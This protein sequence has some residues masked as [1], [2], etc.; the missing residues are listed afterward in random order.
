LIVAVVLATRPSTATAWRWFRLGFGAG[1]VYFAGT[2]Y[3]VVTVMTTFGGL[4]DPVAVLVGALLVAY[5]SIYPAFFAVLLGHAV[6]RGGVGMVWLAP[7]FWVAMEW[8]RSWVGG[9]FPWALLGSSLATVLPVVQLASVTGVYGLSLLVVLVSTAAAALTL[10]RRRPDR[11]GAAVV[12]ALTLVIAAAGTM[13]VAGSALTRSGTVI[14]VGLVQGNVA[15]DRKWNPAFRDQILG[16]YL[17]LSQRVIDAG[18]RLVLWP[19]AATPFFFDAESAL[20]APIRQLASLTRTP[21][22]I[23]TD[24]IVRGAGGEPDRYYNAAVL[25]G[26]DGRSHRSYRKMQLVP[27]GEY[28]PLKQLLFFVGPLVEAVSDFSAGTDPIV[29]EAGDS[30]VS[31]AICYEVV[32]PWIA[33]AFVSQGSQLLAT[34]TNDAWFGRSS[35]P[36]QHF[37]QASIRAV[38]NGRYLVRAANTGISG[39]VDP[40][41]RVL[42]ATPLFEPAATTVDVRLHDHRTIYSYIGDLVAWLSA[43]ATALVLIVLRRRRGEMR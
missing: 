43:A 19:E 33:R 7:I 36:Y 22:L 12:A 14:R 35:A 10:S 41:G 42:A 17:A 28:V 29:F 13:R 38:E 34:I 15:Q 3:W 8:L 4:A 18:A 27:F 32:Y 37:E 21:F 5:L 24:E 30:R 20:A 23:G 26:A 25:V 39:V 16:N 11:I 31:V 40:Y 1:L 9:G 6:R 2:L